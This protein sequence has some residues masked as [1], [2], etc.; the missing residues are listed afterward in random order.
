MNYFFD[1][2]LKYIK[3]SKDNAVST[4]NKKINKVKTRFFIL[5]TF[6]AKHEINY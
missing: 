6:N 4:E 2:P 1:T 3:L 5:F